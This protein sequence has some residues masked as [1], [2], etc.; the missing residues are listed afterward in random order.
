[1]RE[2]NADFILQSTTNNKVHIYRKI[3]KARKGA[4]I[5]KRHQHPNKRYK[6]NEKTQFSKSLIH[7]HISI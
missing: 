3:N 1:M 4:S 7:Y 2:T 6:Y 5:M